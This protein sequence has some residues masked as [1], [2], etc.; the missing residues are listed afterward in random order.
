MTCASATG[1]SA[2]PT[3][4][5]YGIAL[6]YGLF[7]VAMFGFAI[8]S[9]GHREQLVAP[10]YYA[11]TLGEAERQAA[12]QRASTANLALAAQPDGLRVLGAE[13]LAGAEGLEMALYRPSDAALDR[14]LAV[15]GDGFAATHPPL[16]PGLWQATLRWRQAG[17]DHAREFTLHLP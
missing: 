10:D 15:A 7:A 4:W 13:A 9:T 16:A 8:W 14:V 12:R 17:L 5:P 6:G 1:P 3:F 2:R 11:R